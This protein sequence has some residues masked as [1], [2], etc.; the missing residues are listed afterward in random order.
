MAVGVY[1]LA[2]HTPSG[3]MPDFFAENSLSGAKGRLCWNWG[4]NFAGGVHSNSGCPATA[5]SER[6]D[7]GEARGKR[8]ARGDDALRV[9][10]AAPE[11]GSP[12]GTFG[13]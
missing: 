12:P 2:P 8:V 11:P 13:G 3:T 1:P 5:L 7:S 4:W 10:G 9:P 6:C